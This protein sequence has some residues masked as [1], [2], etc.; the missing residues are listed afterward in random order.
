MHINTQLLP[1]KSKNKNVILQQPNSPHKVTFY[2]EASGMTEVVINHP[3]EN[4]VIKELGAQYLDI[5]EELS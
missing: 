5:L 3:A 4:E 1:K 2:Y